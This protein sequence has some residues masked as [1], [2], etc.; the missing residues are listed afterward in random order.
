VAVKKK[1]TRD[2]RLPPQSIESERALLGALMIR[3]D[4]MSETVDVLSPE[5]LYSEKHRMLYRAMLSLFNKNEPV[6][7]ESVRAYLSDQKQLQA[8]G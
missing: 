7:V 8:I 3:P 6:D 5:A 2:L 4:G 1:E